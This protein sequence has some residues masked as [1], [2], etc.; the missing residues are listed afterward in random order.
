VDELVRPQTAASATVLD[1]AAGFGIGLLL[2]IMQPDSSKPSRP[3]ERFGA[4]DGLRSLLERL[5][6]AT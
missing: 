3:Q 4:I 1:S 6:A 5:P 2:E